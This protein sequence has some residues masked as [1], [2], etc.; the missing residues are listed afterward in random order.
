MVK[1][2]IDMPLLQMQYIYR[3]MSTTSI[4]I[5]ILANLEPMYPRSSQCNMYT[6]KQ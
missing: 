2:N 1:H 5:I 3:D 4:D 6:R